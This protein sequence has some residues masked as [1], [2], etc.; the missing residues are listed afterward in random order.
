M[1]LAAVLRLGASE[2]LGPTHDRG[3]SESSFLFTVIFILPPGEVGAAVVLL[4]RL[5]RDFP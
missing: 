2:V 5:S 1:S 4:S 3:A